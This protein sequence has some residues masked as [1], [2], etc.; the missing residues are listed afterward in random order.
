M[1]G[2]P[3]DE[4][5]SIALHMGDQCLTSI[6][7]LIEI[8]LRAAE[9]YRQ[10][11]YM[12]PSADKEENALVG[13]VKGAV[14]KTAQRHLDG[15][16]ATGIVKNAMINDPT[17]L[18]VAD[19]FSH[20]AKTNKLDEVGR[21]QM[22]Q[23]RKALIDNGIGV[24]LDRGIPGPGY[25]RF[26]VSAKNVDLLCDALKKAS[27]DM[28]NLSEDEA[29]SVAALI[30]NGE[31]FARIPREL[32]GSYPETFSYAGYDFVR[33]R[34]DGLK[35]SSSDKDDHR[36]KIEV[37]LDGGDCANWSITRNG[38]TLSSGTVTPL[39]SNVSDDGRVTYYKKGKALFEIDEDGHRVPMMR[40]DSDGNVMKDADGKP[41]RAYERKPCSPN[42]PD[43]IGVDVR[44]GIDD[45]SISAPGA[46][47]ESAISD[48]C[49]RLDQL[50]TPSEVRSAIQSEVD[51]LNGAVA[52]SRKKEGSGEKADSP[53]AAA[54]R[55]VRSAESS[56]KKP[57]PAPLHP[58]RT[59]S[60][61]HR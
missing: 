59:P 42:D 38:S 60:I 37:A 3:E 45:Y 1:P 57:G 53:V 8:L 13:A 30:R 41:I 6:G 33:D 52:Q 2:Q 11:R 44:A 34:E 20:D 39:A 18:D 29:P 14:D 32:D 25:L 31:N 10:S 46:P 55:A 51:S 61:N 12:Q 26:G 36:R 56:L 5:I 7:R 24:S 35:W 27:I 47:L 16:G 48:A 15:Y 50:K 9:S 23:F 19:L 21:R 43:V 22:A 40:R 54:K 4:A 49:A 58:D 17:F 28:P